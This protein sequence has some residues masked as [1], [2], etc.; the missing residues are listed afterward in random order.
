MYRFAPDSVPRGR[1]AN[2]GQ[3]AVYLL[4][5]YGLTQN[6]E[7]SNVRLDLQKSRTYKADYSIIPRRVIGHELVD[8]CNWDDVFETV[9]IL[10]IWQAVF[11]FGVLKLNL[12]S[13]QKF[14]PLLRNVPFGLSFFCFN[15]INF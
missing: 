14:N 13:L 1:P 2:Y 6:Y 9:Q 15:K 10:Y 8:D 7:N 4:D 11:V 5:V 12:I 3:W